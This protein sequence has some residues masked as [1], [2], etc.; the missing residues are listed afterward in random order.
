MTCL[1][2]Y[3]WLGAQSGFEDMLQLRFRQ[4]R[5]GENSIRITKIKQI[6]VE[7]IHSVYP[8]PH[9]KMIPPGKWPHSLKKLEEKKMKT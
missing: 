8:V 6:T 2:A 4:K 5:S 3:I 7:L 1:R 9:I